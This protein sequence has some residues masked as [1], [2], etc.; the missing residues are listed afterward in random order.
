MLNNKTYEP[1]AVV[2]M[3]CRF[4]GGID[5][6]SA[7]WN[8]LEKGVDVISDVP[9]DRW[10]HDYFYDSD[11][12]QEGS[13]VSPQAGFIED[14]KSFDYGFFGISSNEANS[15]DPQQRIALQVVWESFEQGGMDITKWSDKLV[16]VFMGAFTADYQ[17]IQQLQPLVYSVYTPTGMTNTMLSN[18]ISHTFNFKG[19]SMSIDT[20]CSA[21]LT[22]IHQACRSLQSRDSD[23][24]IGGGAMLMLT[25]DFMIGETKTGFLSKTGRCHS[26]SENADGYVRS[27]GV[28]VVILKRLED[29]IRDR[30]QIQGVIIGSSITQDGA[31][32]GIALPNGS[33]QKSAMV[34][35]CDSA[36]IT[37]KMVAFVEAH[38][39]GTSVGDPIEAHSIGHI[40]GQARNKSQP[41]LIGS[42]KSNIGHTE[43][44][45]GVAGLMKAIL[46]LQHRAIP[47]NLHAT[48]LNPNIPFNTLNLQV[49]LRTHE[50][51]QVSG[52][53]IG[54]VNSFGY[55][56]SNAHVLV[57]AYGQEL[58]PVS[59]KRKPEDKRLFLPISANSKEAFETIASNCLTALQSQSADD[60]CYTFANHRAHLKY[61]KLLSA[62][63][64]Q[65]LNEQ[66]K[67]I[68]HNNELNALK[69][70]VEH[71]MIWVFSGLGGT[72]YGS[73]KKLYHG[74]PVFRKA[75][76]ECN[77][78]Y[79]II[80]GE[81]MMDVL[82][83]QKPDEIIKDYH[84][85]QIAISFH[86]MSLIALFKSLGLKPDA[87]VGHSAGEFSAFYAAGVY[88]LKDTLKLI[89]HRITLVHKIDNSG[90]MI[91]LMGKLSEAYQL[92]HKFNGSLSVA[93]YN[94]LDSI[95]VSGTKSA[96]KT[97]SADL[98][99]HQ[100]AFKELPSKKAFHHKH[101]FQG[102]NDSDLLPL[103]M[104]PKPSSITL[105]SSVTGEQVESAEMAR[106]Y[107]QD[108]LKS[109]VRFQET[110]SKILKDHMGQCSFLEISDS[111]VLLQHLRKITK[112]T[113]SLILNRVKKGAF[114]LYD[115]IAALYEFGVNLNWQPIVKHGSFVQLETY[116]WLKTT[117]WHESE[118]SKQRR[119]MPIAAPLL[120]TKLVEQENQ[121]E[122][123]WS[124]SKLSWLNQH[125]ILGDYLLPG[126]TY[127]ELALSALNQVLPNS[128][129]AIEHL[130]FEKLVRLSFKSSFFTKVCLDTKEK[131][132]TI[133]VTEKLYPKDFFV[134]ARAQYRCLPKNQSTTSFFAEK[135]LKGNTSDGKLLYDLLSKSK[136]GYGPEFQGVKSF[137]SDGKS[138][139]C[140]IVVPPELCD[141]KYELH[142]VVLD[143]AFHSALACRFNFEF[144]PIPFQIPTAIGEV[145][146]YRQ[147]TPEMFATSELIQ[148]T[149]N[150]SEYHI[151][152]YNTEGQLISTI[153]NFKT[154]ALS[155][156][157]EDLKFQK[158]LDD[159]VSTLEWEPHTFKNLNKT[160]ASE[161]V[162][163][164][165]K[166][167]LRKQIIKE[168]TSL[169]IKAS[170]LCYK[171]KKQQSLA[172]KQKIML[173]LFDNIP[174]NALV[175]NCLALNV[176]STSD[177][178]PKI[179]DS[180]VVL[181]QTIKELAFKGKVWFVSQNAQAL[182]QQKYNPFQNALWGMAR[183]FCNQEFPENSGGIIDIESIKD[184]KNVLSV[185]TQKTT[186][187]QYVIRNGEWFKLRLKSRV[188]T[189]NKKTDV[190]FSKSLPYLVTGAFGALGKEVVRWMLSNDARNFILTTS[191]PYQE[192]M[193]SEKNSFVNE[194]RM[195]GAHVEVV[196]VDLSQNH[197]I[198]ILKNQ[199]PIK[200]IAGVVYA[201][202]VVDDKLLVETDRNSLNKVVNTKLLGA[203]HLHELFKL[204][205]LEHFILFSSVGSCFPNRG[206]GNYAA[207]NSTLDA[208]A[209]FRRRMGLPALTIN[210]SAWKSG[211]VAKLG[212]E[213]HLEK[214]G[215]IALTEREGIAALDT[216]FFNTQAQVIIQKVD[217]ER[218]IGY[219]KNSASILENYVHLS[220]PTDVNS[221]NKAIQSNIEL[222]LLEEVADLLAMD[223]ADIDFATSL[224]D[225]HIDSLSVVVISE[226]IRTE[227]GVDITIDQLTDDM[228]ISDIKTFVE[229]KKNDELTMS[230]S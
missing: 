45:A 61:R 56:G 220:E 1:I 80:S 203:W 95:S 179:C 183:V 82:D 161:V 168:V 55:G 188:A 101:M 164:V 36:S 227:F 204:V 222:R 100:M 140:S 23:L 115:T 10:N 99:R 228:S 120:G 44:A 197:S 105:Y 59:K 85:L 139:Q 201:A 187:N 48:P 119:L 224:S 132:V 215:I 68:L 137:I 178:I 19:P 9:R 207:A 15:M 110:I 130:T 33:A 163:I 192:E 143:M 184:F 138:S 191:S 154:Q 54:G 62:E 214:I 226:F 136:Y 172:S 69:S 87:V 25:P 162:I 145:K 64:K 223:T 133:Y 180:T 212:L 51:K 71:S 8:V 229:F 31:T 169:N 42:C 167:A 11:R 79:Q 58:M 83:Q 196:T 39:T 104:H 84:H 66:L 185:V 127:V 199:L 165:D 112:D 88:D 134:A 123:R 52:R 155:K 93:A 111:P 21:S 210:W 209:H 218:F 131:K 121:W 166:E 96:L 181:S 46:C 27:E 30:N 14:V 182:S 57:E 109:P 50:L 108:S 213:K 225:Y 12:T 142:P 72:T 7:F 86:Q 129:F 103:K 13:I 175:I 106:T 230:M 63:N 195:Q 5:S 200:E 53:L 152:L 81:S 98:M 205:P 94:S 102:L 125:K 174:N 16:G 70:I 28:G 148:E 160:L 128:Q 190:T 47:K 149:V 135:H 49:P 126:A 153:R 6:P 117:A 76:D 24:A 173:D 211:M 124:T 147:P 150:T 20:A 151:S 4:P 146:V 73:S 159:L 144:N 3:G 40:Y 107:W 113:P 67:H 202:G 194:L 92:I 177:V 198:N 22:S 89:H 217:W 141:D 186:E 219:Q 114:Q 189:S 35:A 193:L 77:R 221:K 34:K 116:P 2:G 65:D 17:F 97:L 122:A 26:F 156:S 41:L 37:P 43:S 176:A 32:H 75:Y 158:D 78:I 171:T 118:L 206:M 216:V 74:E 90:G 18:R 29:A 157:Q 91:S 170:V 60:L 38:G 208:L